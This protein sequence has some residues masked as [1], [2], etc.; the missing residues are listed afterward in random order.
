MELML[1][2]SVIV[3]AIVA[4]TW[5]VFDPVFEAGFEEMQDNSTK[6]LSASGTATG[7]RR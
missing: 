7:D 5:V 3:V 4:A 2:I 1:Y 6:V